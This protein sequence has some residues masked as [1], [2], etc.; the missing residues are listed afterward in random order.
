MQFLKYLNDIKEAREYF[1]TS[2]ESSV[3]DFLEKNDFNYFA[4]V[5]GNDEYDDEGLSAG[6]QV[7][8]VFEDYDDIALDYDVSF[9]KALKLTK[10]QRESLDD[11][12]APLMNYEAFSELFSEQFG[13]YEAMICYTKGRKGYT[14]DD[15]TFIR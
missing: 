7:Y 13:K 3:Q 10:E 4:F 14:H 12:A 9:P 1:I 2:F 11:L 6:V 8:G 5:F 15:T